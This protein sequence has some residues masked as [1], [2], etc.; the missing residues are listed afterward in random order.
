MK[1]W[2]SEGIIDIAANQFN[3]L[4]VQRFNKLKTNLFN[5]STF[6]PTFKNNLK[7]FVILS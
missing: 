4:T 1:E 5:S 6:E 2:K 7:D 3:D